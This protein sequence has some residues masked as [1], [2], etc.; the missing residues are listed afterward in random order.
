MASDRPVIRRPAA[1]I[2]PQGERL[3]RARS[4]CER[5]CLRRLEQAGARLD[6]A[7]LRLS[8]ARP[9]IAESARM[10]RRSARLASA[11]AG[12]SHAASRRLHGCQNSLE[13]LSRQLEAVSP[14]AVLRRGYTVTLDAQGRV[15]RS[16]ADAPA[17]SS[18]ETRLVDGSVRSV[19]GGQ[20]DRT[21]A[22]RPR[23]REDPGQFDLF[24]AGG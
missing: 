23:R 3:S 10:A 20:P 13:A 9:D 7:A 19:V 2:E 16:V 17:G 6:R 12:L 4:A 1:L 15:L 24:N 14:L 5:A 11:R 18:L 22:P 21:R 8:R